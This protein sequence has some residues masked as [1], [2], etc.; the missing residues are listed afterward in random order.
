MVETFNANFRFHKLWLQIAMTKL[1]NIIK[2]I[3]VTAS[4]A[5]ELRE[6]SMQQNYL[7]DAHAVSTLFARLQRNCND[8]LP[9]ASC[10][11]AT[12]VS[13]DSVLVLPDG[14]Y[15]ANDAENKCTEFGGV[16]VSA[17]YERVRKRLVTAAQG[18]D[19]KGE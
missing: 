18:K 15:D 17:A 10:E 9:S 1:A 4:F 11:T 3:I 6:G 5:C 14:M 13:Q 2:I 7:K 16:L 8:F 19:G 12:V